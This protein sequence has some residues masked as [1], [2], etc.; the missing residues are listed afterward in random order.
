MS[1]KLVENSQ[2]VHDWRRLQTMGNKVLASLLFVRDMSLAQY[3][4]SIQES[5][6]YSQGLAEKSGWVRPLA[7]Q[8]SQRRGQWRRPA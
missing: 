4:Q 2:T 8:E 5:E 1:S 3:L 7:H 6:S